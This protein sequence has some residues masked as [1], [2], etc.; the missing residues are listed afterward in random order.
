MN[1][2]ISGRHHK[3][4]R[5]VTSPSFRKDVELRPETGCILLI[6]QNEHP[7]NP[8]FLV[9]EV[10]LPGSGDVAESSRDGLVFSAS[11]LRR[12]LVRVRELRLAGFLTVHTHP[13]ADERVAFSLYDDAQD[14]RLMCNLHELQPTGVFGSLVLGRRAVAGRIWPVG[15]DQP[16]FLDRLTIVG[17]TLETMSLRGEPLATAT[18][19]EVFDRALALTGTG[20]LS[21]LSEMRIGVVGAGGTGSLVIELLARAGAGEIVVFDFDLAERSNLNRVLHL[22]E[23]DVLAGRSKADRLHQAIT[24][25]GLPTRLTLVEGGN[26]THACVAREL[27]GCDLIV[28]CVD[29]DWPRLVMCEVAFQFLIPL[30]DIGTEIGLS[31]TQVQSVDTRVSLVGPGRPCLIC[32]GVVSRDRVRLEGYGDIEQDRVLQMGYSADIRL[33]APAVMDLNMRAA[34]VAM[35]VIRHFLQPYLLTPLPHT[36]KEAVT[37]FSMRTIQH[38]SCTDC[39]ICATAERI[40]IGNGARLTTRTAS[41]VSERLATAVRENLHA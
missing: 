37:N 23:E 36:I 17:E 7:E 34:S 29:C 15:Q 41:A 21:R 33:K 12:A 39:A 1:L 35:L 16:T 10:L 38:K 40:G 6:A 24:E 30:V 4:V 8:C 14:P 13:L 11:Y 22:R 32:S 25:S 27:T 9:A 19:S 2:R 31:D 5:Q 26:I 20:A 28:G 3:L 18:A